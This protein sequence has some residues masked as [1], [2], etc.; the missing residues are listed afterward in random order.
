MYSPNHWKIDHD[1]KPRNRLQISDQSTNS[2]HLTESF[3]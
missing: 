3:D 2:T 1:E